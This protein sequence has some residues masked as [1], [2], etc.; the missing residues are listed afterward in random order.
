MTHSHPEA[1]FV[2]VT[3]HP[4][5]TRPIPI[6]TASLGSGPTTGVAGFTMFGGAGVLGCAA[7]FTANKVVAADLVTADGTPLRCDADAHPDL[8]W[9][10][11]GGGGGYA[12]VTHLE[13]RLDRVPELF[14]G[15]IVGPGVAAPEVFGAWRDWTA[16]LPP[17]MT[18]PRSG[19]SAGPSLAVSSAN[20]SE[21]P[22]SPGQDW[23]PSS[24]TPQAAPPCL[25]PEQATHTP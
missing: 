19:S 25:P 22:K 9:A 12:L 15:Q 20:T 5:W 21:P 1:R 8:L 18:S 4:I 7:G 6:V 17:D 3:E 10:L 16:G 14:G 23:W 2:P 13:L 24:G 11:R